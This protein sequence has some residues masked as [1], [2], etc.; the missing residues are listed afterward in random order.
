MIKLERDTYIISDPH[1]WHNNIIKYSHRP[2]KAS[3]E[4]DFSNLDELER[5]NEDILKEFDKLPL[6]CD[7]YLLGDIWF[8]GKSHQDWLMDKID[9]MKEM[10]KRMKAMNRR[11]LYLI[12]GNHDNLCR[13]GSTRLSFYYSL[14]FD[15][16]YDTPIIIDDN[17]ILSHE[18]VYI[19][20]D[21][22]F[23]NYYGHTHDL[24]IKEDYFT[25]DYVNYAQETREAKQLGLPEPKPVQKWPHRIISLDNYINCCWDCNKGFLK[26][27]VA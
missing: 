8:V 10:V 17:L 21:S 27:Y 14:G 23:I 12:L 2:Y 13:E 24:S 25:Y 11:N 16:V 15:K 3:E 7:I 9:E 18:P 19:K 5:M 26:I 20:P 4:N 6:D 22:D 1:F